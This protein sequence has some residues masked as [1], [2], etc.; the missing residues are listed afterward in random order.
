MEI[1]IE[2]HSSTEENKM[3]VGG[4]EASAASNMEQP[5]QVQKQSLSS[6]GCTTS[7]PTT[8]TA[9]NGRYDCEYFSHKLCLL[10]SLFGPACTQRWK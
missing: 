3:A 8:K 1:G 5:K 9:G 2:R 7:S 10:G 4:D 6:I